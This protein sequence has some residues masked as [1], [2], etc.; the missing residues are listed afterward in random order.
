M[1]DMIYKPSSSSLFAISSYPVLSPAHPNHLIISRLSVPHSKDFAVSAS[2]PSAC[3][4][5]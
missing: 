5:A 4:E 3:P 1:E 2:S